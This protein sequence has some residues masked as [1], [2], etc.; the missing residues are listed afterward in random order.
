MVSWRSLAILPA[1]GCFDTCV[2]EWEKGNTLAAPFAEAHLPLPT[3]QPRGLV[4][5]PYTWGGTKKGT[6]GS[7]D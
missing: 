3:E 2:F 4:D 6:P 1:A 5:H 7:A